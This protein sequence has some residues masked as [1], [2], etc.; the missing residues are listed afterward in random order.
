LFSS[1]GISSFD[2]IKMTK[3]L[4]ELNYCECF[5][6]EIIPIPD[7]YFTIQKAIIRIGF[8]YNHKKERS[9]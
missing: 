4:E 5:S 1:L 2:F 3:V 9:F 7:P 8:F 6:A